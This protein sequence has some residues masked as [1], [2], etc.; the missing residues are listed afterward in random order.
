MAYE[1]ID[2]QYILGTRSGKI[3][4]VITDKIDSSRYVAQIVYDAK[5]LI[6]TINFSDNSTYLAIGNY[7]Q[8][9]LILMKTSSLNQDR[10][11]SE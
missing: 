6:T 3:I 1:Y 7:G 8:E 11:I 2:H 4:R 9:S 5:A 10:V